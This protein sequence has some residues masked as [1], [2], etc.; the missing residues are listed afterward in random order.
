M[1]KLLIALML[2]ISTISF[3][4]IASRDDPYYHIFKT[5]IN[6]T[7]KSKYFTINPENIRKPEVY[8]SEMYTYQYIDEYG[9]EKNISFIYLQNDTFLYTETKIDYLVDFLKYSNKEYYESIFWG[10]TALKK[11]NYLL[12]LMTVYGLIRVDN[13]PYQ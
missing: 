1:K 3:S 8:L 11:D 9:N 4:A 13:I 7:N 10:N 5:L 2:V 6:E 12:G